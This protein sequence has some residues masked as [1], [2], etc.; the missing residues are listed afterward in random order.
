[1]KHIFPVLLLALIIGGFSSCS[2]T[3]SQTPPMPNLQLLAKVQATNKN[4]QGG[5]GLS[6]ETAIILTSKTPAVIQQEYILFNG[7]YGTA[8]AGQALLEDNGRHYDVLFDNDGRKFY[9]DIT[10]YWK[11][12]YG[13]R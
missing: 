6:K 3:T 13:G 8:P 10:A 4:I 2:H 11:H 12:T 7:L 9:F 1:M 5:N